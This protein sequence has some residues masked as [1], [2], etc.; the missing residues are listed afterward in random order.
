MLR[1]MPRQFWLLQAGALVNFTGNGMV[2]PFLV[3]Y[4]H[5]GRGIPVPIASTAVAV[6]GVTAL[7]S[8]LVAGS[9]VDRLGPR[10]V[11]FVAM[12][13]NAFAF[14]LYTQVAAPWQALG[15]GLLVGVGVGAYGPSTQSFI[16]SVVPAERRQAAFAQN[17][18][19]GVVGLGAG[20]MIGGAI[21]A[22]GL[23]GYLTLL[24]LDAVTFLVMASVALLLKATP[25][26]RTAAS[27]R[28]TYREVFRD[29]VFVRLIGV[30]LALV[31]AGIAPMLYLFPAFT[32]AQ[33]GLPAQAIGAIYAANTLTVVV[34]QLPLVRLI[35]RRNPMRVLRTGG[36]V[37]AGCWLACAAAGAW[38]VGGTAIVALALVAMVYALGECLHT[39]TMVPTATVLAPDALRG[40]Y[41]GA[42]ALT[43]QAGFVIGPSL[44]GLLLAAWPI[45]LPV[46]C[47]TGCIAGAVGTIAVEREMS[48]RSE[49]APLAA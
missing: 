47:A 8:G 44:G 7:T 31:S 25:A 48:A 32:K 1:S 17:R 22:S 11:L 30:N 35:A 39:A 42:M 43:W 5:Y 40:R 16:A 15:V 18:V 29:R 14:F 26:P 28:G 6:G 24:R 12:S 23:S 20:G 2:W 33:V 3:I 37:W 49:P 36:L 21:A 45:A 34:A 13:S 4:L 27:S 10:L 19:T 38:L 46:A 41:L 9:L